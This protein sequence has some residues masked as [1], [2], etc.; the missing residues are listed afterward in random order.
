MRKISFPLLALVLVVLDQ[1]SKV[2]TV[3]YIN[4]GEL[5]SFLPGLVSLTYLQNYG[6]AFSIFQHQQWFF[7]VVTLIF[8]AVAFYYFV[9]NIK[10][11][12]WFLLGLTLVISGGIGNFIDR[13][14]QGYVVDMIQLDFVD[15]A[16]FNVADVYL[17]L[18]VLVLVFI[19]WREED[20]SHG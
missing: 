11:N 6:A 2:V 13:L 19:L 4:L 10:G 7:T 12:L 18:G 1:W 15:F 14:R 17:T 16:I 8:L 9:K 3:A 5:K 20:G